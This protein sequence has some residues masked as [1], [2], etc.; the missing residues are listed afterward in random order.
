MG[1]NA[2]AF[3]CAY[4][5]L[6]DLRE[7]VKG[8]LL[9]VYKNADIDGFDV[10]LSFHDDYEGRHICA[11]ICFGRWLG[12]AA[13]EYEANGMCAP[14]WRS[15][16]YVDA[17]K[18][19]ILHSLSERLCASVK[20]LYFDINIFDD[21]DEVPHRLVVALKPKAEEQYNAQEH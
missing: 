11:E 19:D 20:V 7:E 10:I 15:M 6:L 16:P 1:K 8:A 9:D 18:L 14:G 21:V 5:C 2:K 3:A 4:K 12:K 17:V 13:A